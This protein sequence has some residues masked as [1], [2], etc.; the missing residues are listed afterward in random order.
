MMQVTDDLIRSV[1][2]EVLS[3]M[4]NGKAAPTNGHAHTWGAM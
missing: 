4:R 2:Q 1:V 3:H